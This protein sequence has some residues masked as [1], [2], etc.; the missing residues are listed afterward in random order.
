MTATPEQIDT[1]LDRLA[2]DDAFREQM[3]ADPAAALA[4]CGIQVDPSEIPAERNLPSKE[5][6]QAMRAE[7]KAK[8]LD[9]VYLAI[10]IVL[11]K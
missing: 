10:F 4:S 3:Q 7:I 1:L 5:A 2:G 8:L 11:G 9:G 6:I